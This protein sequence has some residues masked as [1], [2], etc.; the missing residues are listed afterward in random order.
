MQNFNSRPGTAKAV[1]EPGPKLVDIG[2]TEK[3]SA[4]REL[5]NLLGFSYVPKSFGCK[6]F[7]TVLRAPDVYLIV[8]DEGR[9]ESHI[10]YNQPEG[11]V[12]AL[13]FVL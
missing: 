2:T 1:H 6:N 3:S 10:T 12:D 5:F 7:C 9:S 8:F 13:P 4:S 11:A